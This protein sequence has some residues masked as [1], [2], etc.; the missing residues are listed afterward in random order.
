MHRQKNI[1][2]NQA[3]TKYLVI[4]NILLTSIWKLILKNIQPFKTQYNFLLLENISF[5]TSVGNGNY[6]DHSL[7]NLLSWCSI[8]STTSTKFFMFSPSECILCC[9]TCHLKF[10]QISE[11][12]IF[13]GT[14]KKNYLGR[15]ARKTMQKST[16]QMEKQGKPFSVT[17]ITNK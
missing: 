1:T 3:T 15:G 11:K 17:L 2:T 16:H 7:A 12:K 4:L 14:E 8:F 13:C 9:F 5:D 6:L 10:F